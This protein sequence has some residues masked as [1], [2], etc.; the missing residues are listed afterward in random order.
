MA[1]VFPRLL[2]ATTCFIFILVSTPGA[3]AATLSPARRKTRAARPSY[4]LRS[5]IKLT[6]IDNTSNASEPR[7]KNS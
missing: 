7:Q 3:R 4:L 1:R 6:A 2:F 5:W